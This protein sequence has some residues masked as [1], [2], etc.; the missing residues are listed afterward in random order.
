MNKKKDELRL[1]LYK[2]DG[3]KCHY[4]RIKEENFIEI[5]GPF[6]GGK[7]RG[8]RLEIDRKDNQKGYS[9]EN[10]VLACAICNNAKSDK[11]T[12]EEFRKLGRV[13]REIWI[14]RILKNLKRVEK[15]EGDLSQS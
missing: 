7:T 10:C 4:C 12:Y 5:W 3:K 2:R 1:K 8:K 6:Y 11:F 9:E 14:K 13:I 15:V